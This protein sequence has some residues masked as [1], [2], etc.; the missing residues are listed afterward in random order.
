M[1]T[2]RHICENPS[3]NNPQPKNKWGNYS[4]YCCTECKISGRKL[5]MK[6]TYKSKDMDSILQKRKD[7]LLKKYGVDNASRIPEVIEQLRITSKET[8]GVRF[9]KT[10][11]NNLKKYGVESI[12]SLQATQDKKRETVQEKYGVDHVLKVPSIA[13]SVSKK[14][15]ENATERLALAAIT[16]E[17]RHGDKNYNNREKYKETCVE[18]FG[19][20]NPSQNAE[21]H[22]KKVKNSYKSKEYT[23]PSGKQALIQ[24][25]ENKAL[26]KLLESY[27]E[28]DII[29][30]TENIPRIT[31]YD[32]LGKKHYYF[33][34]IYIPK[35]NL[36]IEVKS[37][38]TY[39]SNIPK[40][41]LKRDA[42]LEN[43]FNFKFMI[44]SRK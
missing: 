19:V 28:D 17:E 44:M 22:E 6:E 33:P 25:W 26:D 11:K 8:A 14:N 43:G 23:F 4:S 3:C 13:A 5:K 41:N 32:D 38:W 30:E 7:T 37:Q 9:D 40:H 42:C 35:E 21:V 27:S 12:N 31:Y 15:S 20:E 18:R 39:D 16:K 36:L 34:D 1:S 24:G 29:V 2:D 10:K